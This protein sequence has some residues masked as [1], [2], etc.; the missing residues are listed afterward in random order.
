MACF[1]VFK[2]QQKALQASAVQSHL[3][4]VLKLTFKIHQ[5]NMNCWSGGSQQMQ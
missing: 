5:M 3:I 4:Q 2:A 1:H